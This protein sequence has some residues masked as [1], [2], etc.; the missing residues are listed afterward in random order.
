LAFGRT[1]QDELYTSQSNQG[2]S[3]AVNS[4]LGQAVNSASNS[5]VQ[6]LF[7]VSRVKIDPQVGGPENN[8]NPRVTIEQQLNNNITVTYVTNISQSSSQ[9]LIQ[10]E[11]NVTRNISIV[12]VRD[13]NG[14]LSFDVHYRQRKR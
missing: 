2:L 4:F 11:Y 6:K 9:Q 13:Q 8:P 3:T 5:R 7:G 10:V 14:I 1:R 12:A